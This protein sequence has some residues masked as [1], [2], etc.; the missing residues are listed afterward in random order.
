LYGCLTSERVL[1]INNHECKLASGCVEGVVR[2]WASLLDLDE[3]AFS[4][5]GF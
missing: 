4:L 2:G 3:S 1:L 5:E